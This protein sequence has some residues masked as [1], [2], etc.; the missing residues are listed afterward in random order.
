MPESPEMPHP[1]LDAHELA[2]PVDAYLRRT[3][4]VLR[5]FDRQ[6]SECV[7]YGVEIYGSAA[8]RAALCDLDEHR[9]APFTI[10]SNRHE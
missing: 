6:D 2:E 8:R 1:L 5:I 3:G 9:S 10:E 7:S 4:R